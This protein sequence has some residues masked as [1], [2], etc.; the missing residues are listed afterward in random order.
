M[1]LSIARGVQHPTPPRGPDE[2]AYDAAVQAAFD[3]AFNAALP[4]ALPPT[5]PQQ[6]PSSALHATP[7][8]FVN[9]YFCVCFLLF[10][11]ISVTRYAPGMRA[12]LAT[13][14]LSKYW[15]P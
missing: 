6:S 10:Q 1:V 14:F 2:L 13:A 12:T 11:F 4:A 8:V 7:T 5:V 15:K 3:A 9:R